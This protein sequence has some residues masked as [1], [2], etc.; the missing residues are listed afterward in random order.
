MGKPASNRGLFCFNRFVILSKA[1][2]LPADG[3]TVCRF[4]TSFKRVVLH[5][6]QNDKKI[7]INLYL[8]C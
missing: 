3:M 7:D 4:F 6:T 1:N 5:F 8:Q 2:D